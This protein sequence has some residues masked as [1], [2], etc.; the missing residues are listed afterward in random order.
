M[1]LNASFNAS[2][3][4]RVYRISFGLPVEPDVVAKRAYLCAAL[5]IECSTSGPYEIPR[6]VELMPY[7]RFNRL[8]FARNVMMRRHCQPL[9][10][11]PKRM[12]VQ[13]INCR[14]QSFTSA[15]TTT[16]GALERS[17]LRRV[18]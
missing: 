4:R 1:S 3:R 9:P 2:S 11:K 14:R 17:G 13:A 15:L 18:E 5:R 16:P 8:G 6:V 12:M 7:F 10:A